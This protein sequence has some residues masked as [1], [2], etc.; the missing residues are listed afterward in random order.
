M[1][2]ISEL[3]DILYNA[4]PDCVFIS[5]SWLHADIC[6]GLLDPKSEYVVLQKDRCGNRGGGVS[7]LTL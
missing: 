3:Y 4:V 7:A 1:N 2:K 5:E 6:D